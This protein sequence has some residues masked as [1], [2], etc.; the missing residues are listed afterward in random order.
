MNNTPYQSWVQQVSNAKTAEAITQ[1]YQPN[2]ILIPTFS[3]TICDS[4][5]KIQNYFSNLI[6]KEQL[7][8]STQFCVETPLHTHQI[9]SNGLYTFHYLD[10]EG[11]VNHP[12]RFSFLFTRKTTDSPWLIVLHHSSILPKK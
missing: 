6:T 7:S 11:M 5:E 1:L 2:A 10:T 8:I 3:S 4:K 9:L 12:A